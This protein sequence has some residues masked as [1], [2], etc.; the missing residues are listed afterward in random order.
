[1]HHQRADQHRRDR[2][3]RDAERQHRHEG[4][5]GGGVVRQFRSGHAG[6][7]A[8]AEFLR[9]LETRRSSA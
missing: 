4:A 7:G 1:M 2:A 3:G 9:V 6:D 5:G 8:L